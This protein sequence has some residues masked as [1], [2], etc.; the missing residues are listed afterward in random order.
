MLAILLEGVGGGGGILK[1]TIGLVI[2]FRLGSKITWG[3]IVKK[4][5]ED[6]AKQ[7]RTCIEIECNS[8]KL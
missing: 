1:I 4:V 6:S 2:I 7:H 8:C 3:I 5:H